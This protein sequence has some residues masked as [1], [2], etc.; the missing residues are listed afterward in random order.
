MQG[1][2]QGWVQGRCWVR[3]RGESRG[4]ICSGENPSEDPEADER[5]DT[6]MATG[7]G[8]KE[9]DM[10]VRRFRLVFGATPTH[11]PPSL[12]PPLTVD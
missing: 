12:D 11:R 2:I 4:D 3:S 6:W 5:A 8:E 10:E 1:Q 9:K 7:C